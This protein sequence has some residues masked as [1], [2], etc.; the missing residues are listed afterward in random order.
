MKHATLDGQLITAGPDSPDRARCPECGA[1]VVKRKRCRMDGAVTYFYRHQGAGR[2]LSAAVHSHQR[3][4]LM[5]SGGITGGKPRRFALAGGIEYTDND[6]A[7]ALWLTKPRAVIKAGG[8]PDASIIASNPAL[9]KPARCSGVAGCVIEGD[10]AV[11]RQVIS[12]PKVLLEKAS[13]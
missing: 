5:G 13:E 2:G 11:V 12:T 9:G 1:S 10:V 4:S 7:P 3:R 6:K 8:R